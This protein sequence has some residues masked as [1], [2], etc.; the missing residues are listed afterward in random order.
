MSV[1]YSALHLAAAISSLLAV[2]IVHMDG[3]GKKPGYAWLFLL[4]SPHTRLGPFIGL[5][6]AFNRQ[7][8]VA[9]IAL[10]FI[11]L[12]VMP[13]RPTS[14]LLLSGR[15]KQYVN[16]VLTEDGISAET[17]DV[18]KFLHEMRRSLAQPHVLLISLAG[19][20]AGTS[21]FSCHCVI[22]S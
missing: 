21:D 5:S 7:E 6:V 22:S 11:I 8:G 4:V 3:V 16:R 9:C 18:D 17:V 15:E 20:L 10:G 13:K 12:L 14:A 19:F 2:G 1:M